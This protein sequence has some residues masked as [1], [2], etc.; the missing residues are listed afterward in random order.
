MIYVDTKSVDPYFNFGA[1]YYFAAE[2][3]AGDAVLILWST[4]PTLMLGKYQNAWEEID[5]AYAE[6]KGINLVRR[7][8]GGGTIYTDGGGLQYS[9]IRRDGSR[10]ISFDEYMEPVVSA[11]N[12]LGIPAER[13][14]RNDILL[15]GRKISGNA[16]F[17]LRGS[18]VHHGSLLFDTDIG[19]MVR[20]TSPPDYKITSKSIKSV[21]D[22]VTNVR[23]YIPAAGTTEVFREMLI[24]ALSDILGERFAPYS[25]TEE[26]VRRIEELAELRFRG[27][28]NVFT[29]SPSFEAEYLC[30]F[31]AG[32]VKAS[33]SVKGG[34][35]TAAALSGDY[36]SAEG[37]SLDC[38]VGAPFDKNEIASRLS[39]TETGI[40]GVTGNDLARALAEQM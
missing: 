21:R 17:K 5:L 30:R 3:D 27:R 36:F 37:T 20:S 39:G 38:L 40:Y 8:S 19:E 29:P 14:G 9:F 25:L 15:G 22:R 26:D 6:E 31:P 12:S 18:T 23:E 35:I 4:S 13:G 11:L 33:F 1:E 10:E 7:L 28:E 2:K 24:R 34:V 16:Q 32:N